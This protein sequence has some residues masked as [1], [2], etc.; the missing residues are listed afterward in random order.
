M[1]PSKKS[2]LVFTFLVQSVAA[3]T[4]T[5]RKFDF[6][7]T[8]RIS[9]RQ[10]PT[11]FFNLATVSPVRNDDEISEASSFF[12]DAFFSASTMSTESRE[13]LVYDQY[14]DWVSRYG[15]GKA[16][17]RN[18]VLL[19]A[20]EFGRIVGTVSVAEA[21]YSSL[22]S[23]GETYDPRQPELFKRRDRNA[24]VPILS[25]LAVSRKARR[26]GIGEKLAAK[27]ESLARKWEYDEVCNDFSMIFL[28]IAFF[29]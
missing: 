3:L 23:S 6:Q 17:N 28:I 24:L 25:N 26:R 5:F 13:K 29:F 16:S 4:C 11:A 19:V 2:V 20:K 10:V 8:K 9:K 22:G 7:S 14:A 1:A 27:C 12:V 18:G 21:P 15:S